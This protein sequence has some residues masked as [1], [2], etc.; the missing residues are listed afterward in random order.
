MCKQG[1]HVSPVLGGQVIQT[2]SDDGGER[3]VVGV[4]GGVEA[5]LLDELPQA[6]DQIEIGGVRRQ[7]QQLDTQ[8]GRQ[9]AHQR[10]LLVARVVQHQ[11]N[12]QARTG[13]DH[14][15]QQGA[16]GLSV[17]VTVIGNLHQVVADG[18]Q[19]PKDVEPFSS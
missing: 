5:F 19:S 7:V 4:V 12:R 6:F 1:V 11:R 17:D 13:L 15:T 10:A 8:L 9:V 3:L 14:G 2:P 18:V 16:D